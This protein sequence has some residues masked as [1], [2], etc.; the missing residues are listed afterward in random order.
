MEQVYQTP[1]PPAAEPTAPQCPPAWVLLLLAQ[2]LPRAKRSSE[3]LSVTPT[4]VEEVP[5]AQGHLR[6]LHPCWV[7]H[8][9]GECD[10]HEYIAVSVRGSVSFHI[11]RFAPRREDMVPVDLREFDND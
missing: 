5:L 7:A 2:R 9:R 4:P 8:V 11:V 1:S 10:Q 6:L 3:V